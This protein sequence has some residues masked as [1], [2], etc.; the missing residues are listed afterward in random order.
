MVLTDKHPINE[1]NQIN[2]CPG[3][4]GGMRTYECKVQWGGERWQGDMQQPW[5]SMAG[6]GS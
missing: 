3:A 6:L 2:T 4:G 1:D 5:Q